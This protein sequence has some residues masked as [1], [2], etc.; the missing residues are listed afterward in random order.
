MK[1]STLLILLLPLA[2]PLL[3]MTI[4]ET[5]PITVMDNNEQIAIIT[6][7]KTFA[8]AKKLSGALTRVGQH[9]IFK[10]TGLYKKEGEDKEGYS[11]TFPLTKP[12]IQLLF[13]ICTHKNN[14][15]KA[16][17]LRKIHFKDI[18]R[19][20]IADLQ[21]PPE[22]QKYFD[23]L[24][25]LETQDN[26]LLPVH[27]DI[28]SY[29][30][31]LASIKDF[32]DDLIVPLR[33]VRKFEIALLYNAVKKISIPTT[34]SMYKLIKHIKQKIEPLIQYLSNAY[35]KELQEIDPQKSP[36]D[37]KKLVETKINNT[38][39][40]LINAANFLEA[41][42]FILISLYEL[43]KNRFTATDWQKELQTYPFLQ[44]VDYAVG[45]NEEYISIEQLLKRGVTDF[46]AIGLTGRD[47]SII[48]NGKNISQLNGLSTIPGIKKCS[49]MI[50][51][52]T[53]ISEIKQG[54]F[55]NLSN[56]TRLELEKN[57]QLSYLQTNCFK[58]LSNLKDLRF[59][60]NNITTLNPGVLNLPKLKILWFSKNNLAII[61]TGWATHL[62]TLEELSIIEPQLTILEHGW[63]KG[64]SK[65]DYLLIKV[66]VDTNQI[67]AEINATY[68]IKPN[69]AINR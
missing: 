51:E 31:P 59:K 42:L 22:L 39:L 25:I 26:L 29:F 4:P 54:D 49:L 12:Q 20:D 36:S 50:I 6:D 35:D 44:D 2:Q 67:N 57:D 41:K 9:L 16:I 10:K 24:I 55:A 17:A 27:K 3:P 19:K 58:G 13:E 33:L 47:S 56:I 45:H 7:S 43:Y 18:T 65:L 53:S 23:N 61:K 62:S 38:F 60:E 15:E 8:E 14:L 11:I 28:F 1:K 63:L 21:L 52:N 5:T 69:S 30:F 46:Y 48:I 32:E 40:S 66:P 64:L 37:R 34:E 68:W